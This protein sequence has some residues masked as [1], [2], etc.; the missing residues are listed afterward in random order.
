[1]SRPPLA[2]CHIFPSNRAVWRAP[3]LKHPPSR[4]RISTPR[5]RTPAGCAQDSNDGP[6]RRAY[7]PQPSCAR[8]TAQHSATASQRCTT[9][10]V[11][12]C[13]A[14]AGSGTKSHSARAATLVPPSPPRCRL[15]GIPL[16]R[17]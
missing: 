2:A 17:L 5:P 11:L 10:T 12:P 8:H 7:M 1:M 15:P 6:A 13:R 9:R 4:V 3:G 16:D 14:P